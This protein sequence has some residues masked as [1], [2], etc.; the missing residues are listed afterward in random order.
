MYNKLATRGQQSIDC[1]IRATNL[2]MYF[3]NIT[4]ARTTIRLPSVVAMYR[5]NVCV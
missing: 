4:N 3:N 5:V 1:I 2:P